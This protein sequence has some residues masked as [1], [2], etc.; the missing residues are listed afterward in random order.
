MA[1]ASANRFS[2]AV[3]AKR[4]WNLALLTP[5]EPGRRN[6]RTIDATALLMA[7]LVTAL[8]AVL[9]R[10]ARDVDAEI[11]EALAAL[12]GWAPNLWRAAFVLA[13]AFAAL[14]AGDIVLRRRW[15]LA[16]DLLLALVVVAI[17]GSILGRM[18]DMDWSQAEAHLFS[19]WGFPE[20][21]LAGAVAVFA[22]AG[23]ELV[24]PARVLSVWVVGAAGLGA[25][26]LG[27]GLPSQVLGGIALGLAAGALVRLALGSAAGVPP[28]ERVRAALT[29]LG[30]T[31]DSLRIADLQ[32]MGSAEF[33]GVAADG[34]SIKIR[35][36]GRDAQE[37][38]RIA[39]RWRLLAYR[40]PPRSAPIG[41]LEQV[42]HEAVATLMAAQAGVRVPAVVTV[43][44]GPEG[45]AVLVTRQPDT[46]PLELFSAAE[47]SDEILEDLWRQ[48]ARLHAAGISHGRLNASNV[49]VADAGPKLVDFSA[50]TL[51]A[52]QSSLDIDLAE[53]LVACTVLVGPERA[54]GKAIDA[55]WKDSIARVLPYLQ[56]AALTPHLRDLA[57][58]HEVGLSDL[59]VAAA[60]AVG[61][62]QPKIAPLHRIQLKDIALMAA[63]IFA[64]YLLITQ[65]ADIGFG[66]I[67]DELREAELV[68]VVLALILAQ[69]TFV[70]SGISVRGGVATPL[71]LL[72][73]I[74]LQSALKF[75][76]L[77][78][79]S[80]AGR[81]ATNLRCLQRMGAPRGEAIAGGALDDLSNTIVQAT[82]FLLVIPFVGVDIDTSQFEGASPDRRLLVAIVVT[83]A[84]SAVL[85]LA[86]PRVRARVLPGGR[87]ALLGLWSVARVRRKRM[88][89]FGGSIASELL[90]SLAL[91]ATCLA[92]GV[93]LNIGQLIFINTS[94][95]VLSSAVPVPGGI[96]AAEAALSAGLIAM[97]VD[98]STAFA[99]AITQRLCT[100]Y[101]PPIWGFFSLRWLS[102]RGYL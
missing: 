39:R 13:L 61:T 66:T 81:V 12:L 29:S 91:G 32:R 46:E 31:V 70:P 54:L 84:V 40:D 80:S 19:N 35:V 89:V 63:V 3:T 99:I 75:I 100:F 10:S 26:V 23:P 57:R 16:R 72:P 69:S 43:G 60:A 5:A 50:A 83:L 65:L 97:G 18:V 11:V 53:L 77:T 42:E 56:R 79:P 22:V 74:V 62:E 14:I 102:R 8:A 27:G 15:T 52:P 82:L 6:R 68:W 58:S 73:C 41:R 98:Q 37:T 96:G 20:F 1:R 34:S 7:S 45:D 95:S 59:R 25:V 71:P 64:A 24:R 85:L 38:Q 30:V 93:H 2:H 92:Y 21:R 17:V 88:E 90:Y 47:V 4:S 55:G 48:V 51:G 101:L 49:L 87:E 36:L 33:F 67:A 28:T 44:L 76:N 9:A 94:A 78:V 86:V